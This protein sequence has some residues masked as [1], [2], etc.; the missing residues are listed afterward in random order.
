[1]ESTA[2]VAKLTPN[3]NPKKDLSITKGKE[4]GIGVNVGWFLRGV[5]GRRLGVVL[6]D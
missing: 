3:L 1:M 6:K 4:G 5:E 2:Q